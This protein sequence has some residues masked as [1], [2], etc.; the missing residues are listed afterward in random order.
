MKEFNKIKKGLGPI[1]EEATQVLIVGT[2]PSENSL[3][4]NQYY[5]NPTNQFWKLLSDMLRSD[6][7]KIDYDKRI[8]ILLDHNFGIWDC[9]SRCKRKTSSDS[10]II[11]P[12]F[13]DFSTLKCPQL[14]IILGNSNKSFNYLKKCQIPKNVKM[15]KLISSSRA[16]TIPYN[17]KL[18]NWKEQLK[19]YIQ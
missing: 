11:N 19:S 6:L 14:K 10:K 13:N 18:T 2:F 3:K 12:S 5:N 9:I 16:R 15:G 17:D 1:C 8:K 4:N 7:I